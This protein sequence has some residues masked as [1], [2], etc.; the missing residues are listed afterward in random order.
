MARDFHSSAWLVLVAGICAP[1]LAA[2]QPVDAVHIPSNNVTTVD[3]VKTVCTGVGKAS[4]QDPRWRA[5][6]VRIESATPSGDYLGE[7]TLDVASNKGV[8][9]LAVS[10]NSPW[11]LMDL[12][13]GAYKVTAWSG[14]RGPKTVMVHASG[15]GQTRQVIAFP[16]VTPAS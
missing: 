9:V 15:K 12:P 8:P 6:A 13:P 16:K 5:F 11:I 3:G 14:K 2:A 7:V 4:R 1:V 10:C